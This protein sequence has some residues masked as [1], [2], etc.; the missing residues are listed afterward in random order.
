MKKNFY[1]IY[2]LLSRSERRSVFFLLALMVVGMFLEMIGIGLVVPVITLMIQGDLID[3]FPVIKSINAISGNLSNSEIIIVVMIG[4]V[5]VY[6]IKNIFLAYLIWKQSQF[7][8]DVQ[9]KLSN[10]LFSNYLLQPYTFHLQRNSAELI[11]NVINETGNFTIALTS[12]QLIITEFLVLIGVTFLLLLV[13]PLGALIAGSVLGLF[14]WAFYYVTRKR[15]LSWGT[16]RQLHDGLRIQHLQQGLGGAKDVKLLGRESDFLEQF[17]FH[18]LKSARVTKLQSNLQNYPRLMFELLA[19]I[20]LAILVISMRSQGKDMEEIIPLLGLF[21]A[22]AF[23]LMPSV[24]R[25]L[26]SVQCLRYYLP[27]VETIDKE[28]RLTT[29]KPVTSSKEGVDVFRNEISIKNVMYQYPDSTKPALENIS[30]DISSGETI[31]IIGSSGSG[32]STLVDV[33]LGLLAPSSGYIEVDEN[34]IQMSLRQW[35]DQVGYVPQTIY[36]TDDTLRRNIAFG[37]P[38]ELINNNSVENAIRAAQLDVFVSDLKYGFETIVGERGVRLSGGQRQ[39]IGIARAL[40]HDPKVL[41]FDEATSSL[42]SETENSVMK[43]IMALHGT[44]TIL[45]VAHRLS[46]VEQCDRIYRLD[47]GRVIEAGEPKEIIPTSI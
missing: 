10:S 5:C 16:D 47:N 41:V 39:R 36:L 7:V 2:K 20:G 46:T 6:A 37:I 38:E 25:I 30:I 32:K 45:I 29:P 44:K 11:R 27:V 3:S 26:N 8:Y 21:A 12:M 9:V 14:A 24:N 34:D 1:K 33:I 15:M 28:I 31:G 43:T 22:A 18:N 4:L 42:D 35:Q 13:E 23:R 17:N 19:V 40:Y